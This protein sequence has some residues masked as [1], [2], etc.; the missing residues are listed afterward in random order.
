M[1]AADKFLNSI[2]KLR[3]G[4]KPVGLCAALMLAAGC[5]YQEEAPRFDI[6]AAAEASG[7]EHR[8]ARTEGL[9]APRQ[10][11]AATDAPLE[12]GEFSGIEAARYARSIYPAAVAEQFDGN[13]EGNITIAH[14]ESLID[15]ADLCDVPFSHLVQFNPGL[16]NPY[17]VQTGSLVAV[18]SGINLNGNAAA[19]EL[20]REIADAY[21]VKPG[22][23][24]QN[25]AYRHNMEA[26]H[27]LVMN[28]GI[29][30]AR[31]TLKPG[32]TLWL[33]APDKLT[34][35]G[36]ISQHPT[37]RSAAPSS[38]PSR[39][40]TRAIPSIPPSAAARLAP[41]SGWEIEADLYIDDSGEGAYDIVKSHMPY[42]LKPVTASTP[43][44]RSRVKPSLYVSK[45]AIR[46]GETV[47]VS[48]D[49]LKA[50]TPVT[51]YRGRS[52]ADRDTPRTVTA[53]ANGVASYRYEVR[54]GKSD[55]GGVIYKAQ[56]GDTGETL[57]SERVGVVRL[58]APED[59]LFA[60][61]EPEEEIDDEEVSDIDE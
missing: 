23:T 57:Y 52:A 48:V 61:D 27:L 53:D 42:N 56:R 21:T 45:T 6:T 38:A 12:L 5:A 20:M 19:L 46:P 36:G 11:I 30:E 26:E 43:S 31:A 9:P 18:P 22:D 50:G 58:Q 7:A 49:S 14:D 41:S 2:T 39:A 13:C 35:G 10:V 24:V 51:F 17:F 4:A 54:K 25:V 37:G 60:D 40:V 29:V 16:N 1:H 3:A 47:V 59:L 28:P 34:L 33:P 15:I 44:K 32:A 8:Y 55:I